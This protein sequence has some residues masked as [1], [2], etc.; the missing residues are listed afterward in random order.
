MDT[1]IPDHRGMAGRP[2]KARKRTITADTSFYIGEWIRALGHRPVD[3]VRHTGINEGYLSELISGK[4][5]N[6][7]A[8]TLIDI[9]DFLGI[10][11]SYL[12]Q[13]PP[14]REFMQTAANMDPAVLN[15]LLR[16]RN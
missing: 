15:R 9:A 10:P 6:P 12:R 16:T 2:R 7:S 5:R 8:A 11:M 1:K 14:D 13:P 3:I 4:K